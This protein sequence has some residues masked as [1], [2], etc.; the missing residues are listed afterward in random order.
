MNPRISC[1]SNGLLFKSGVRIFHG[2]KL[3]CSACRQE[4]AVQYIPCW[5]ETRPDRDFPRISYPLFCWGGAFLGFPLFSTNRAKN[6]YIYIYVYTWSLKPP[7]IFGAKCK[8]WH[9]LSKHLFLN[10]TPFFCSVPSKALKV[11][12][13]ICLT[14]LSR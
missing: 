3:G 12:Q 9:S 5:T 6:T 14:V 13:R 4:R 8:E 7:Q 2:G 11:H 10:K 1:W